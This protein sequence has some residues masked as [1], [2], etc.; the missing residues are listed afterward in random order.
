MK[1]RQKDFV[2]E[3]YRFCELLQNKT[4]F[5]F[6]RFSDGELYILQNKEL[7]LGES[8]SKVGSSTINIGYRKEDHKHFKPE[9]HSFYREKLIDSFKYVKKNYFKGL[10]CRCCVGKN[11]FKWQLDFH[12]EYDDN[13][14]WAN[15][16]VNGNYSRFIHEMYPIFNEY[17]TVFICNE[18]ARV[19]TFPFVVKDFRVG[20]N[21]MIN[22][23]GLIQEIKDWIDKNNIE[24][25]LFLFSASSFSKMA[26]HQLFEHNT[27]NTFIDVGTTLNSFMDMRL[28]RSYLK[29]FW[30][31]DYH[32]DINKICIW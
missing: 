9:E 4:P 5:A 6:N 20:Y 29:S 14:T 13:F 7:I 23:Y 3:F 25:Y 8:S 17:K 28:D 31:N 26:I 32:P 24:G 15:L 12:G 30:L 1:F 18:H 19:S 10:S 27:K 2:N 21:A 16:L 22:D 11:E